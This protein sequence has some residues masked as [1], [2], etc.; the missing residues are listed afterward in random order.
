[1]P[2]VILIVHNVRSAHNVGSLLRTADGLG[3]SEVI[4]SGYTP[5]PT[6]K[7]DPR[8]PH[9]ASKVSQRIHKTALGAEESVKWQWAETVESLLKALRAQGY[10][11]A[12]LE[13]S[14]GSQAL[15]SFRPVPKIALL[16]GC[17]TAGL[18]SKILAT[19]DAVL[20][21]PM[22]GHKESFNVA[23]AAAMALYHLTAL[24]R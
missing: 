10:L 18:D 13:Q 17:E 14:P 1:M 24:D 6:I 7:N 16:V 3:V 9:I 21:I 4:L 23:S 2:D 5:Y 15:Q 12:A 19:C 22:Q 20:E 11:L 8:L